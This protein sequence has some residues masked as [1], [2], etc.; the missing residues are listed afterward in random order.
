MWDV[1]EN[2]YAVGDDKLNELL[3]LL[4]KAEQDGEGL[5]KVLS[6]F[7][8]T[9]KYR[10][11]EEARLKKIE[12]DTE[13]II[14]ER[15]KLGTIELISDGDT[16]TDFSDEEDKNDD[17]PEEE[18][19]KYDDLEDF[20]LDKLEI[21][22]NSVPG[23][24]L[25]WRGIGAESSEGFI[26]SVAKVL[27]WKNERDIDNLIDKI[28]AETDKAYVVDN[29]PLYKKIK[30]SIREIF[31]TRKIAQSFLDEFNSDKKD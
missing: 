18:Y 9:D 13:R 24:S 8:D 12:E 22:A 7:E 26:D 28:V 4:E 17:I 19:E 6:R 10:A 2:R 31:W 30:K 14:A 20:V 23:L 25:C 27:R 15:E 11:Y 29:G 21:E 5:I 3:G 16:S 1:F